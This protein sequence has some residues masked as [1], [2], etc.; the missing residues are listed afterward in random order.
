MQPTERCTRHHQVIRQ[1]DYSGADVLRYGEADRVHIM[2][3]QAY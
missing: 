2:L 1:F 3:A